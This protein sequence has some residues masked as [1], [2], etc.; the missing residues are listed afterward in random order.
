MRQNPLV[1]NMPT[2]LRMLETESSADQLMCVKL[3]WLEPRLCKIH[4]ML[5]AGERNTV[6]DDERE[7]PPL[8]NQVELC[9]VC[10]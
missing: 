9:K 1:T 10:F 5:M 7:C 8:N 2:N 3:V 6:R 4:Q